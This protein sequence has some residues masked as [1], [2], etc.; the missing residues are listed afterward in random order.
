MWKWHD[1]KY[2]AFPRFFVLQSEIHHHL[3]K[4]GK[5][6]YIDV[7]ERLGR[8]RGGEYGGMGDRHT[9]WTEREREGG[10]RKKRVQP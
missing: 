4:R 1:W 7:C 10:L 9:V 3:K 2:L 5:N 6:H 8:G